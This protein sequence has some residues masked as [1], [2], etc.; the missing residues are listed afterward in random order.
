M[1]TFQRFFILCLLAAAFAAS[2]AAGEAIG[3]MVDR[4]VDDARRTFVCVVTD[5]GEPGP[6][7]IENMSP[8]DF[9]WETIKYHASGRFL[10]AEKQNP[11]ELWGFG[12]NGK[13]GKI[14]ESANGIAEYTM[15]DTG[16]VVYYNLI[17]EKYES[18]V[19]RADFT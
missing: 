12:N 16:P 2:A 18:R 9:V 15:A 19:Y 13:S 14:A 1:K 4:T 5:E 8:G 17:D 11:P 3:V 7:F 6:C 10:L